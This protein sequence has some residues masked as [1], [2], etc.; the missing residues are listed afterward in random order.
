MGESNDK[1]TENKGLENEC[2][3]K[4]GYEVKFEQGTN[5]VR[6]ICKNCGLVIGYPSEEELK[7]NGFK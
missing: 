6:R 4:D 1:L 5:K 3:H 7:S 2:K